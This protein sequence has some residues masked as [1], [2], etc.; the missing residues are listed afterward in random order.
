MVEEI[1]HEESRQ[2]DQSEREEEVEVE[3]KICE[4]IPPRRGAVQVRAA[5]E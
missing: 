4:V 2:G 1:R 5:L 3:E